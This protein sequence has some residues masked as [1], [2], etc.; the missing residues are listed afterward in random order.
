M[1]IQLL[2]AEHRTGKVRWQHST[3]VPTKNH[4][5]QSHGLVITPTTAPQFSTLC[6]KCYSAVRT[7]FTTTLS[8]CYCKISLCCLAI[9]CVTC[10]GVYL[11][12]VNF[13]PFTVLNIF[14]RHRLAHHIILSKRN[15]WTV[16]YL[17]DFSS[18]QPKNSTKKSKYPI[19]DA[20]AVVVYLLIEQFK[21]SW[22]VELEVLDTWLFWR[23]RSL[24]KYNTQDIRHLDAAHNLS[25]AAE[26]YNIHIQPN[27]RKLSAAVRHQMNLTL[28]KVHCLGDKII[29]Y[30]LQRC[31]FSIQLSSTS[32]ILRLLSA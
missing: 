10:R 14:V 9:H 11:D 24:D 17:A 20:F 19:S 5:I 31:Y 29:S 1:V 12:T 2:Y 22:W 18:I 25:T 23:P 32:Y 16:C 26:I 13:R 21:E 28:Y 4:R 8:Q 7:I 27:I 6:N 3:T 15:I 30:S